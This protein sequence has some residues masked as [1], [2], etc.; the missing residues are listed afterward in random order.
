M[1]DR[2]GSSA[3]NVIVHFANSS[4]ADA[5]RVLSQAL[6]QSKRNDAPTAIIV[7]ASRD[8]L[9]QMRYVSGVTYAEEDGNAW[10]KRYGVSTSR[11]PV[12]LVVAPDGRIVWK[13]EGELDGESLSG[14]FAK[15]LV[16]RTPV[17]P[18]LL[19]TGTR[20]G[21]QAPNFLF[22]Y[23]PGHQITFSKLAGRPA[24][25]LFLRPSSTPIVSALREIKANA[26]GTRAE[27]PLVLA[28]VDG[29]NARGAKSLPDLGGS[30]TIVADPDRK[31]ANAYGV[32]VWPTTLFVDARGIVT[33]SSHGNGGM[34]S[35]K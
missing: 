25:L 29:K 28:I 35:A 30:V 17:R 11:G 14:A 3:P 33:S 32:T 2:T 24:L 19:R 4:S 13:H 18:S 26:Q 22:E 5:P 8:G 20:I 27:S 9:A 1:P 7:V 23:A 21:Q 15:T 12:T 34:E 6:K 31:I 10:G 16:A